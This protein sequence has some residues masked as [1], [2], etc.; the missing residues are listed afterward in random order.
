MAC[1]Q[2]TS[3]CEMRQKQTLASPRELAYPDVTNPLPLHTTRRGF[4]R[5]RLVLQLRK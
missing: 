3:R 4:F 1:C 5:T 2:H